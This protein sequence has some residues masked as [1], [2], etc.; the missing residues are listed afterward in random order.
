MAL[1]LTIVLIFVACY[2][3]Y[4]FETLDDEENSKE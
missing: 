4:I 3:I 1:I 2:V